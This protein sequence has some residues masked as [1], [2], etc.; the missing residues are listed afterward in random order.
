MTLFS[1]I[2]YVLWYNLK[3]ISIMSWYFYPRD[4]DVEKIK[5][6]IEGDE[7]LFG[8]VKKNYRRVWRVCRLE[9]EKIKTLGAIDYYK[10]ADSFYNDSY[11]RD[12]LKSIVE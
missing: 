2:G 8:I 10:R 11:V 1:V 9:I 5:E 12:L 6:V 7:E 3:T 4:V